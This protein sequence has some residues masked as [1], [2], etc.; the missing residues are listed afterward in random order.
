MSETEKDFCFC[1]LALRQKYRLLAKQLAEDLD[2]YSPGTSLVV[3][4]DEP[5]DFREQKN[6]LAFEHLQKGILHCYNDKRFVLEKALSKFQTAI[7]IDSDTRIIEKVP[8]Y[9]E[10]KSGITA[11]TENLLI[12]VKKYNP[13]RLLSLKTV[14]KKLNISID[15]VSWVGESLFIISRDNGKEIEFLKQWGKI[16]NYL[17]LKG[18]HSGEGNSI[19]LAAAKIGWTVNHANWDEIKAVTNHLDASYNQSSITFSDNLKRRIG[20]HYRLNVT[21]LQALS[22]FDFYYR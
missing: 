13:E 2:T 19:G 1:T 7:I 6:V 20:Y 14:A 5:E 12:H 18:I 22:D 21:R 15:D 9:I 17:E 16:G 10:W 4:T 3:G 8:S 11:K